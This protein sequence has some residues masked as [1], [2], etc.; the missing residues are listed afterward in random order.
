MECPGS[1]INDLINNNNGD[2][3][4]NTDSGLVVA[5]LSNGFFG[6]DSEVTIGCKDGFLPVNSNL[7][8][9]KIR[10]MS[11]GKWSEIGLRCKSNFSLFVNFIKILKNIFIEIVCLQ[12]TLMVIKNGKCVSNGHFYRSKAVCMCNEGFHLRSLNNTRLDYLSISCTQFG[13]WSES[14]PSCIRKYLTNL[15]LDN[16]LRI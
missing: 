3:T 13:N 16:H 14:I 1:N 9:D 2:L 11:D 10:C 15:R 8:N 6:V 4:S 12:S 7:T 5:F